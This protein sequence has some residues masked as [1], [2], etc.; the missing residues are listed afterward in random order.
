[1]LISARGVVASLFV[2]QILVN[3][4]AIQFSI[5]TWQQGLKLA[6]V[7]WTT[8]ACL[9]IRQALGS[10]GPHAAAAVA[11]GWVWH[12]VYERLVLSV[13]RGPERATCFQCVELSLGRLGWSTGDAAQACSADFLPANGPRLICWAGLPPWCRHYLFEHRPFKLFLLHSSYHLVTL[14]MTC[15]LLAAYGTRSASGAQ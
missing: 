2:M 15:G 5:T 10:P 7:L 4:L 9:N 1:V 12:G 13:E 11:Y 3:H 6:A 8:D 14:A